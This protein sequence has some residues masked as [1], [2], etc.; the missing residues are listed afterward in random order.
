MAQVTERATPYDKKLSLLE[1]REDYSLLGGAIHA[2]LSAK[3][4]G[5]LAHGAKKACGSESCACYQ[6]GIGKG[7]D[8]GLK[9]GIAEVQAH[10]E[11]HGLAHPTRG[12]VRAQEGRAG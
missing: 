10:P 5:F 12:C 6:A 7:Y 2:E 3:R 8:N 4:G 9:D 1:K 11:A